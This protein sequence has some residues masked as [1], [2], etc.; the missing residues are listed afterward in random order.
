MAS[1]RSGSGQSAAAGTEAHPDW[2]A[3]Y[4]AGQMAADDVE[5]FE[6]AV[7]AGEL[8][9]PPSFTLRPGLLDRAKD[10]VTGDSRRTETTEAASDITMSPEWQEIQSAGL[11]GPS[12]GASDGVLPTIGR[13]VLTGIDAATGGAAGRV[14]GVGRMAASPA[15]QFKMIVENNPGL[16]VQTDEKGNRFFQ[17]KSG[18]MV[19]EKPGLRWTDA[20]RIA[21][22]FAAFAPAGLAATV[23]K[24]LAAGAATQAALE[25]GQATAGGDFD[26]GEV[27]LAGGLQ[28]AG[29]AIKAVRAAR[30]AAP[31]V[32]DAAEA[33][34][35]MAATETAET[36]TEA[37]ARAPTSKVVSAD[38]IRKATAGD[39]DAVR[40]L[41][42]AADVDKGALEALAKIDGDLP[43]DMLSN[44]PQIRDF[45]A[46]SR[47]QLASEARAKGEQQ[48]VRTIERL[49][50]SLDELGAASSPAVVS[51]KVLDG[52]QQSRAEIQGQAKRLYDQVDAALKPASRVDLKATR[53]VLQKRA[54]EYGG[55]AAKLSDPER[56]LIDLA[57]SPNATY[58]MLRDEKAVIGE[59]LRG[60]NKSS[61][62]ASVDRARLARL[63]GAL[64][65]DQLA[66]A[67][68]AGGTELRQALNRANRLT[69]QQKEIESRAIKAFGKDLEGDM[70]AALAGALSSPQK[71]GAGLRK[72]LALV[73]EPLRREAVAT[74]IASAAAP[75]GQF[76]P[77][78]FVTFYQNLARTPSVRAQVVKELGPEG[79][80][81]LDSMYKVSRAIEKGSKRVP[82]T[83][84]TL[85]TLEGLRSQTLLQRV[86]SSGPFKAVAAGI[87]ATGGGAMSGGIG[88]AAGAGIGATLADNLAKRAGKDVVRAAA[89]LLAS[90]DFMALAA[91]ASKGQPSKET[92]RKVASSPG[93]RAYAKAANLPRDPQ[94]AEVWLTAAMQ[95]ARQERKQ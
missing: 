93:W 12:G 22:N 5:D 63:E 79:G 54:A 80:R 57:S 83:G 21:A 81:L 89:D 26:V 78:R 69:W 47:Q 95:A 49:G 9:V 16:K 53:D 76:S 1:R 41:A 58:Q 68:A 50:A 71:G 43:V 6:A 8:I 64:K 51:E 59:V 56:R 42:E 20:P 28:A 48:V 91:A 38:V 46:W 92:I 39:V 25:A 7:Q 40:E 82:P 27:A 32:D 88:A 74:S 72:M 85:Q 65:L 31:V 3:A 35:R 55:D 13:G 52:L 94:A 60:L 34:A 73:P 62:Y 4:S 87:G 29:P 15:E 18:Q 33:T 61:P 24:A 30:G 86:L 2:L 45:G 36:V 90:D 75:N 77:S 37:G 10:F 67:E 19:S 17:S 11:A 44:N 23:P 66:A 84:Q 70:G 14:A